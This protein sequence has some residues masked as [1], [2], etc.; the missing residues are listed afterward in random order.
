MTHLRGDREEQKREEV[1]KVCKKKSNDARKL[2][3][4][5]ESKKMSNTGR[6]RRRKAERKK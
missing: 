4:N 5:E 3:R 1:G 6:K 2:G